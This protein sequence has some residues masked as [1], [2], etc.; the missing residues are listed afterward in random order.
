MSIDNK[1]PALPNHF[2]DLLLLF[3]V[4]ICI[5][6]IVAAVIYIPQALANPQ[7]SF[8]YYSCNSCSYDVGGY[9]VDANGR[10]QLQYANKGYNTSIV[11]ALRIY[12]VKTNSSS[13]ISWKDAQQYRL[14]P[15]SKSPDGYTLEYSQ[16][17]SSFLFWGDSSSSGW[18][19]KSGM[20]SKN[21]TL[22]PPGANSYSGSIHFLGWVGQ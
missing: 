10:A 19:L 7:Y 8:V 15:S 14:D 3:S 5:A 17:N 9:T 18:Q 12:N 22:S 2:K 4:P 6:I 20:Q 1:N 11:S 21:V 13:P 16:S